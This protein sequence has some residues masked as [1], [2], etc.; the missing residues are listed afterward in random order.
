MDKET[1]LDIVTK[2]TPEEINQI[3]REKGKVKLIDGLVF[4]EDND[5]R[6]KDQ[7]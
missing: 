3:I 4:K 7:S 5:E 1:F 2:H 6:E